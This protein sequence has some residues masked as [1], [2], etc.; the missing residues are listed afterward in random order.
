[1]YEILKCCE[2]IPVYNYEKKNHA[3][4]QELQKQQKQPTKPELQKQPP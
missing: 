1:M 4:L 3:K 2:W